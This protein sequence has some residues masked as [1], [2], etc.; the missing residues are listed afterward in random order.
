M[1]KRLCAMASSSSH[2]TNLNFRYVSV[3]NL[4]KL[5]HTNFEYFSWHNV[6]IKFNE[7]SFNHSQM[8]LQVNSL[9]KN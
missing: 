4:R 6:H 1:R 8:L 3:S 2:L 7:N 5:I 9:G